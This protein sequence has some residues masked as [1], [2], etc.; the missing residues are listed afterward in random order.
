M[1]DSFLGVEFG[2][3]EEQMGILWSVIFLV[4]ALASQLTPIINRFFKNNLSIF[5]V[6]IIIAATLI[7]SPLLGLLLGGLS[8]IIR[9]SFEGIFGNLSSVVINQN[10]ES[11][12]RATT[13]STF[14]MIKNIPYLLG[15]YA[16]GSVS[17]HLSAKNVA[18]YLGVL[19]LLFGVF[20]FISSFSKKTE[21][22]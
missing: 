19:L 4:S 3:K 12:Y 7:V 16:I 10:T 13:I 8:L 21:S 17:D 1:L 2:F 18:L 6:G 15:A 11:R 5:F 22:L 14:N 20:Q 9:T